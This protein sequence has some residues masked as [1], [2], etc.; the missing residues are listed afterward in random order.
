M[1]CFNVFK[2]L[3]RALVI[4]LLSSCGTYAPQNTML[5]SE[6][7]QVVQILGAPST[8]LTTPK[9]EVLIYAKGPFGKHTYF[10]Y[11]NHDNVMER[12]TQVLDEKNFGQIK[13]GMNK[14]EI[15]ALIG[16]SKDTFG[17]ARNRGYVWNYRYENPYCFW[18][19]VEFTSEHVVR[20]TGYSKPPECRARLSF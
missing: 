8:R 17:L 6:M 10:V 12:W 4:L 13:P 16:V 2:L 9:G 14:E 11:F 5:G 7:S 18:F 1:R 3:T 20:S 15:I 19:Q